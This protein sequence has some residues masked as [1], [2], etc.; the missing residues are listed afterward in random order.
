VSRDDH[1]RVAGAEPLAVVQAA[2]QRVPG[3][4]VE[5]DRVR[6]VPEPD[7]ARGGVDVGDLEVAQLPG[8]G[9]VQQC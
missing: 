5:R 2:L 3:G 4:R 1:V 9:G 8:R 7:G 6:P